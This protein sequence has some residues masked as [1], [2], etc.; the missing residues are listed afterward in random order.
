[1]FHVTGAG[2]EENKHKSADCKSTELASRVG[3]LDVQYVV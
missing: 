3:T 1:M 2:A